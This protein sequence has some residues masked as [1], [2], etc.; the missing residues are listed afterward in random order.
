VFDPFPI[1]RRVETDILFDVVWIV[2]FR[3]H[4]VEGIYFFGPGDTSRPDVVIPPPDSCYLF[5]L[6]QTRFVVAQLVSR[7]DF[8]ASCQAT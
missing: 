4:T 2:F 7:P 5:Y 3:V 1:F 6:V 8:G